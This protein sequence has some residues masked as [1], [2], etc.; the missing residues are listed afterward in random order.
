MCTALI[1]ICQFC[2]G[3]GQPQAL[4]FQ[5][6]LSSLFKQIFFL[7]SHFLEKPLS[8]F[9][10]IIRSESHFPYVIF[11]SIRNLQYS[12]YE[13][14]AKK[15]RP[16]SKVPNI[17]WLLFTFFSQYTASICGVFLSCSSIKNNHKVTS[18]WQPVCLLISARPQNTYAVILL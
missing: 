9:R 13:W 2:S 11:V 14:H 16:G 17:L 12:V 18:G 7:H 10:K 3:S 5:V 8:N 4:T 6:Q 1:N 15:F